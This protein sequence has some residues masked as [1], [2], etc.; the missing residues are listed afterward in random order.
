VIKVDTR[1][2][3][4]AAVELKNIHRAALPNAVRSTLNDLAFDVK[5]ATLLQALHSTDMT[6]R[7]EPFFKKYSGAVK[8]TGWDIKSMTAE[9]GMIPSGNANKAVERLKQQD[10][11]GQLR[12]T[13]I[14]T[15]DA[16]VGKSKSGKIRKNA[17]RANLKFWGQPIKYG[18]TQGLIKAVTKSGIQSGGSGKGNVVIYGKFTYE[19][20]GFKH[21]GKTKHHD[22]I[23]LYLKKLYNVKPKRVVTVKAQHFTQKA[24]NL[25]GPKAQ[26]MFTKNAEKQLAKW[27]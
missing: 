9:V 6:I 13:A 22:K 3:S 10:E 4:R 1:G 14:A 19:I 2:I 7:N 8:A 11:G 23:K 5:K 12:H 17:R 21:I 16:R 24:A 25:S 18:D 27:K 20:I 15:N 26:V